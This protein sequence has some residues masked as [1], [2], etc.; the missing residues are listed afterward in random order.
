MDMGPGHVAPATIERARAE[1]LAED[2]ARTAD[3]R[4]YRVEYAFPVEAGV[5]GTHVREVRARDAAA[6]LDGTRAWALATTGHKVMVLS[7]ADMTNVPR[8]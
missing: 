7:V 2:A 3:L 4:P 1:A 5:A 8:P 6:A